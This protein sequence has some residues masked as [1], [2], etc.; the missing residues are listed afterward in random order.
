[1]IFWYLYQLYLYLYMYENITAGVTIQ[2]W[3]EVWYV[4]ASDIFYI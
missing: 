3:P 1:M 2:L 4:A